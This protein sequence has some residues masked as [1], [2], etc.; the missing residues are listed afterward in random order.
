MHPHI[1]WRSSEQ[2]AHHHAT[3]VVWA[4]AGLAMACL[5]TLHWGL[6]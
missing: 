1:I 5:V 2:R 6:K 4:L 3:L